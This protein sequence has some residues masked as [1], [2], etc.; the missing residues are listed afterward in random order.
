MRQEVTVDA[1]RAKPIGVTLAALAGL[2]SLWFV[3]VTPYRVIAVETIGGTSREVGHWYQP[4][5]VVVSVLQALSAVCTISAAVLTL[6]E[7]Y[8]WAKRFLLAGAVLGINVVP[9]ST[10]LALAAFLAIRKAPGRH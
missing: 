5:F 4:F 6:A 9:V 2:A 7:R 1:K 10:G 8:V 3:V